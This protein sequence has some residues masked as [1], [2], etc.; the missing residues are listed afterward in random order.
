VTIGK[1]SINELLRPQFRLP[2][3]DPRHWLSIATKNRSTCGED[4]RRQS[5]IIAY[6]SYARMQLVTAE[7][8]V[9]VTR[10]RNCN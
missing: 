4:A 3:R 10:Q 6:T 2:E 5:T 9:T 8:A 7:I 1:L